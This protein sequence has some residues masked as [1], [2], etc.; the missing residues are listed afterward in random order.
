MAAHCDP[1]AMQTLSWNMEMIWQHSMGPA[2]L[3]QSW[4]E[5]PAIRIRGWLAASKT[6]V[7]SH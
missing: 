6:M 7:P 5:V 2:I 3:C 4:L 1:H